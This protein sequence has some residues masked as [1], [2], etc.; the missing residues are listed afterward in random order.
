MEAMEPAFPVKAIGRERYG[1]R[2]QTL[3]PLYIWELIMEQLVI[4]VLTSNGH[5][6]KHCWHRKNFLSKHGN[7]NTHPRV[8]YSSS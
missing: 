1:P 6:P 4:G 7:Q 8:H 2:G 5:L 3:W